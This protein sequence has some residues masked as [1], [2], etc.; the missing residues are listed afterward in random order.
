METFFSREYWWFWNLAL[1]AALFFPV[2]SLIWVLSVR[3]S[4]RREGPTDETTRQSMKRR[5]SI[6]SAILCLV[7][8]VSYVSI[9]LGEPR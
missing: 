5:A 1:A 6:T 8:S 3:R 4:E 2:R 9:L 7:F